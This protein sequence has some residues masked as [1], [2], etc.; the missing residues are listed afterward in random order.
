VLNK[1]FGDIFSRVDTINQRDRRTPDD[2]KDR[3]YASVARFNKLPTQESTGMHVLEILM[4]IFLRAYTQISQ[5]A[6][7]TA[8]ITFAKFYEIT[9]SANI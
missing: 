3:A 2:S 4:Y 8:R 5:R 9:T 1:K 7:G 6:F